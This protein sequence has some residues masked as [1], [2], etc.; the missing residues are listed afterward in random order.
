MNFGIKVANAGIDNINSDVRSVEDVEITVEGPVNP[1][2]QDSTSP[3]AVDHTPE[4]AID[5]DDDHL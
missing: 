1:D 5:Q 2:V 3:Y 4:Y